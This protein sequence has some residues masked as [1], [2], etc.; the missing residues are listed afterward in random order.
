M[1]LSSAKSILIINPGALGDYIAATSA[2]VEVRKAY[3]KAHIA[4]LATD[5][6]KNVAPEGSII[7]ELINSDFYKSVKGTIK[8]IAILRK[9][10][11]DIVIN[12]RWSSERELLVTAF[13][14]AKIRIGMNKGL[15]S[16]LYSHSSKSRMNEEHEFVKKLAIVRLL[17]ISTIDPNPFIYSNNDAEDYI[18][19]FFESIR[20]SS[21]DTIL[22]SPFASN[23]MKSWP[24]GKFEETAKLIISELGLNVVV[25][26]GPADKAK[27]EAFVSNVGLGCYL[28]P[29]TNISQLVSLVKACKLCLCNNSGVMN[30]AM[31][32]KTPCVV[33]SCTLE[34]LWGAIGEKN[35]TIEPDGLKEYYLKN[36]FRKIDDKIVK[37]MLDA[38]EVSKVLSTIS[39][40][41]EN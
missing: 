40:T 6:F 8:L 9:R 2:I 30:I 23:L 18:N 4:M 21:K 28:S 35:T 7:D 22:I 10:K 34:Q 37:E 26:F 14:G 13:S 36:N 3:P 19:Y 24:Q 1:L 33:V 39:K 32:T 16:F 25:S 11:F 38:I 5:Y 17:G 41:L 20:I 12:L 29:N 27:A 31:A 15:L